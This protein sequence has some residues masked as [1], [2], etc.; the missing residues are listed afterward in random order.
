LESRQIKIVVYKIFQLSE[1]AEAHRTMERGEHI[2]K[3]LLGV[4]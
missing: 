4:G 1:A 3:I 2:G